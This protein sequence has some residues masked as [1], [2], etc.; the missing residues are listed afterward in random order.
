AAK[1]ELRATC[2][3]PPPAAIPAGTYRNITGNTA[4]A[5]GL[6]TAASKAGLPIF[7]G[8]Y[9]ITPASDVLHELAAL[10][11]FGVVTFQ[12]EDEI[13][14]IGSALGASF[15]GAIGV[16][17]T[18]GPGMDLKAEALGLAPAVEPPLVLLDLHAHRPAPGS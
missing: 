17:T 12:A 14:G 18:S 4:T 2:S 3:E 13:A 8:S 16:T 6:V 1:A 10:K 5:L 9:P 7:L 11:Q 15:G